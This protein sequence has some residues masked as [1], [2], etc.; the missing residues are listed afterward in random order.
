MSEAQK[1]IYYR[2]LLGWAEAKGKDRK[3]AAGKFRSRF[4]E[5]PSQTFDATP[6]PPSPETLSYIRSQ[7]IRYAMSKGRKRA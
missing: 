3:Q 4:N 5:W 6:L 7:N 2:E 1:E